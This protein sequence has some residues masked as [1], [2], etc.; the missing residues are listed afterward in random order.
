MLKQKLFNE[1]PL[2]ENMSHVRLALALMVERMNV[3]SQFKHYFD[4]LPEKYRT[5]L[6]FTPQEMSELEG[7]T[8]LHVAIKQVKYIATQYAFLY[9][10]MMVSM[11]ETTSEKSPLLEELRDNFTYE[12]YRWAVS[13]VMTRQNHIPRDDDTKESVLIPLWDFTNHQNGVVNTQF[14]PETKKIESFCLKDFSE[15]EE[16]LIAYG[17]RSNLDFLIHNG[18]VFP[19]NLNR[20]LAIFMRLNKID[21]NHGDRVKLLESIGLRA[22]G[23][24]KIS[25]SCS[26]E[27]L[28]FSR[29]FNMTKEQLTHWLSVDNKTDLLKV[30]LDLETAFQIKI[31]QSLLI[32]VKILQ[33]MFPTTLAEDKA[34]LEAGGMTKT[35]AML[36]Q[37]RICVKNILN[38]VVASLE[39]QIRIFKPQY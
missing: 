26:G 3:D 6:Y 25:P 39:G 7:T 8:A 2:F 38:D 31:R 10:Y 32:R 35:R 33:K 36:I 4:V 34:L 13:S 37:Y 15:G 9:K 16:V 22:S 11:S 19:E 1:C 21:E 29:I 18:F 14:N 28:G 17:D 24:W 5:V 20:D 23:Y 30:D 27:I 12:F